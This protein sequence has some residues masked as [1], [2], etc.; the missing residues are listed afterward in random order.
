MGM[1]GSMGMNGFGFQAF[2]GLFRVSEFEGFGLMVCHS[3]CSSFCLSQD[4]LGV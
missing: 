1:N 3:A 4:S 2:F